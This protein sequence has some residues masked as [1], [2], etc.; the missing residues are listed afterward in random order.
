[1]AR[2]VAVVDTGT[3]STRLLVADIDA[4][5]LKE[6]ARRTEIT[7]LG[8]GVEARGWLNDAAKARVRNCFEAY[9]RL[10]TYLEAE[11]LLLLATSSVRDAADGEEFVASLAK[12]ASYDYRILTGEQEAALAFEGAVIGQPENIRLLVADIGGGSTE[13]AVGSATAVEAAVS[14]DIGCVRMK[15]KYLLQ[16]PPETVEMDALAGEVD[17]LLTRHAGMF[18]ALDRLIGVAG[19]VTSLAALNLGLSQYDREQVHGHRL[20]GQAINRLVDTLAGMP[21]AEREEYGVLEAGRADV[22]VAGGI[23]LQRLLLLAGVGEIVVSENDI[24]DGAALSYRQRK[25]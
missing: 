6:V 7:R 9:S 3:N 23:I 17:E 22:I 15:E 24:L 25:L 14:I 13:L 11:D 19:T 4:G 12:K 21:A 1:M 8:E 2:R 5:E 10:T 18:E 16:D 20:S